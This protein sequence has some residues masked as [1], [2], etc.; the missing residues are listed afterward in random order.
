MFDFANTQGELKYRKRLGKGRA[1][2]GGDDFK[3][4]MR[5]G[6]DLSGVSR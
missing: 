2:Q 5:H 6:V 3:R 4:M 1:M